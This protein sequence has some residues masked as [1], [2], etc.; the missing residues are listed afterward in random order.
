MRT[1]PKGHWI[2][3]PR[4][5]P[6]RLQ[7]MRMPTRDV[8][9]V[10]T[11][12]PVMLDA[13]YVVIA[14]SYALKISGITRDTPNPPGGVIV[15]DDRGEPNGILRNGE[16]LLK[17]LNTAS[18]FTESEKLQGLE[19]MLKRYLAAGLTSIGDRALTQDQIALYQK[20]Y[21]AHRLPMRVA[22]TWRPDILRPE[23]ELVR[24]IRSASYKTGDGDH[25]LRFG[26]F[27]VNVDGGM[28]IGTAYMR[29][30]YGRFGWQLYGIT[31]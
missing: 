4:T 8:L 29:H 9:D 12:H 13:S 27:K 19:D 7:E 26:A 14:N 5:F 3:V 28:T 15:H 18:E 11:E 24:A 20:L 17:G 10:A 16:S 2:V 23:E 31:N 1:T 22:M 21:A 30:P 25:W 6:T